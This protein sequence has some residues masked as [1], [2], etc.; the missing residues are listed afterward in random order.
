MILQTKD[1]L[2][3]KTNV[4]LI[5]ILYCAKMKE[6]KTKE[7]IMKN[8]TKLHF[9]RN[10]VHHTLE[11]TNME[12]NKDMVLVRPADSFVA[13]YGSAFFLGVNMIVEIYS[14]QFNPDLVG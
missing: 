14:Y 5:F 12:F 9:L 6:D 11:V 1:I 4:I 7:L 2:K 3:V 10:G 13:E 8:F